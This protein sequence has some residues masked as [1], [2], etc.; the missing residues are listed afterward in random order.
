[1]N[2]RPGQHPQESELLLYLDGELGDGGSE[3]V[4]RHLD[5]CW[6]CR[7]RAAGL[8]NA[9]LEFTRERE[10]TPIPEPPSPWRDLSGDFRRIQQSG[11]PSFLRRLRT[12][13]VFCVAA[14]AVAAVTWLS[15]S[16]PL[17]WV[18]W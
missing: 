2:N 7:M 3:S 5:S 6:S 4:R 15:L 13:A 8:Q 18:R 9:I 11:R 14:T 1:M 16:R 12:G 10:R 17:W